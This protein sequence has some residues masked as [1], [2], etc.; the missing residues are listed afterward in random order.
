VGEP[1]SSLQKMSE[2]AVAVRRGSAMTALPKQ[3]ATWIAAQVLATLAMVA[4]GLWTTHPELALTFGL[5][6]GAS[7][8]NLKK[9]WASPLV[10]A[11]VSLVGLFFY[12][13]EWP[14]VIG[15]GAAAG[16]FATWLQPQRTDWLDHVHGALGVLT[17]S[18][19][20]LWAAS[21]VVPTALLPTA[22]IAGMTALIVALVGSWGLLP[23]AYRFDQLPPLPSVRQIRRILKVAYRRPVFK[24]IELYRGCQ[25]VASDVETRRG[26]AEVATWVFR[27]Q[28][29]L[30]TLD[31]ELESIDPADIA[32]RISACEG[33]SPDADA[34]TRERRQATAHHLNRLLEHRGA[35]EVERGR[36]EAVVDYALAFLEEAR[37]SL[38]MARTLPGEAMPDRLSEVLGRLRSQ[39]KEGDARRRT[40]REMSKMEV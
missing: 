37:A 31:R 13:Q 29:T 10:I 16:A 38:A 27:L 7:M 6:T 34:F 30:Q 33:V 23:V 17:G 35:I 25:T 20:G 18:S 5:A 26:M 21:H 24:A 8:V 4:A 1:A 40:A 15:A 12:V 22:L 19:L 11:A 28:Q 3:Q 2:T 36:T 9:L 14:V 32:E 39:A